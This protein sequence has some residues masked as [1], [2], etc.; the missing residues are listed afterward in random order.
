MITVSQLKEEADT[1][2]PSIDELSKEMEFFLHEKTH[3][4]MINVRLW[5]DGSLKIHSTDRIEHSIL[6][7]FLKEY[8]LTGK[9]HFTKDEGTLISIYELHWE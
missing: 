8:G 6:K 1:L 9:A 4:K 3:A 7:E 2:K 5:Y